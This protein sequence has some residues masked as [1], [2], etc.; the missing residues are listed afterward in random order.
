MYV[1]FY[2]PGVLRMICV[3]GANLINFYVKA[4]KYLHLIQK[5]EKLFKTRVFKGV[6]DVFN[7]LK[8]CYNHCFDVMQNRCVF[9]LIVFKMSIFY[10]FCLQV[11]IALFFIAICRCVKMLVILCYILEKYYLCGVDF[12][13]F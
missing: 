8:E 1:C 5:V 13:I 11:E 12:D 4:K 6:F 9:P 3:Y 7:I 2:L 10:Y